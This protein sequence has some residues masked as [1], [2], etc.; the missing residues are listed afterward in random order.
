MAYS[1]FLAAA[2][3]A[4]QAA[5]PHAASNWAPLQQ[6]HN[7]SST[8]A[9][10]AGYAQ[11]QA[12]LAGQG[13][14]VATTAPL[15]VG[16]QDAPLVIQQTP[17]E[18][19]NVLKQGTPIHLA[20]DS[21]M[22]SHDNRVGDRVDLRVLDAVSL[23]GH[24]I[25]PVGTRGYGEVTLVRRKGMWGK[26]GR[27]EFRP[28]Y[29][30]LGG[31]QIP[32]SAHQMTKE[33]GETGTAGVVASIVVLPLAGFFVTGTSATIPRGSSVDAELSEDLPVVFR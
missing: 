4:A 25:I 26:S 33:H 13:A 30:M 10:A 9:Q 18:D 20:T 14:P 22:S 27:I 5:A 1:I 8:Q 29:L 31:R 24:T 2:A 15:Q 28:L 6:A 11:A 7:Q 23:N 21:E 16:G 12:A 17:Q 19:A 32:V 3:A